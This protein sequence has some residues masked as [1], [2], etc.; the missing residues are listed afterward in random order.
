MSALKI[1]AKKLEKDEEWF[2]ELLK[3][4]IADA[5]R[6]LR[7][8]AI[9][10]AIVDDLIVVAHDPSYRVYK[11]IRVRDK[12]VK[13]PL[14]SPP[15]IILSEKPLLYVRKFSRPFFIAI[16]DERTG[17]EIST[18]KVTQYGLIPPLHY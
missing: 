12:T 15:S 5:N 18:H 1:V 4:I 10:I 2:Q 6:Y 13:T 16:V 7:R 11:M 9:Y 17:K 8:R 14:D 3:E